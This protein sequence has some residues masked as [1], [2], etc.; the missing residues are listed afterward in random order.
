M[1]SY[2]QLRATGL[3]QAAIRHRLRRGRLHRVHR[4]V[5]AVG[6][7]GLTDRGRW[8]AATL[9]CG[10]G[11]VLSYRS[12]AEL[13]GMLGAGGGDAHVTVP[14]AGGRARRAG[15]RIHRSPSLTVADV[16][17][18]D[19]IP[20]TRPQRTLQDIKRMVS[21]GELR[22][23]VRQAELL[24]LPIDAPALI[25]DLAGSALE[26]AFL[27]LCAR[28][29]I[30]RPEVNVRVDRYV[31]DFLWRRE[32]LIVETDGH[33]YHRGAVAAAD[34]LERDR[35]LATLGFEVLRFTYRDVMTEPKRTAAH[36]RARLSA[37]APS[38]DA[39]LSLQRP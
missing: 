14:V 8:K 1:I 16:T 26:L 30:P 23:A 29:R 19:N 32:R 18:R 12:A 21:P 37:R 13:W 15:I 7:P 28:Y 4:A 24:D 17:A 5:Y 34:D 11:A 38:I 22:R 10:A 20:V 35:R 31:I 25:P 39:L 2:R 6:H 9:A 3:S 33:R 27:R 36:V